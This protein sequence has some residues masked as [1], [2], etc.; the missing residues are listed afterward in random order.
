MIERLK[1]ERLDKIL[2]NSGCGSR[3]DVKK[4]IHSGAVACDGIV[5]KDPDIKFVAET[6]RIDICGS[7]LR[8]SKYVYIMMH[9]PK[10][11]IS[12]SY[13]DRLKTVADLLP[14]RCRSRGLFP[15]GRLDI[16][17]TGLLLLTDDGALAHSL[18]SPKKHIEKEYEAL[19]DKPPGAEAVE[20]FERGVVLNGDLKL[21]PAKLLISSDSNFTATEAAMSATAAPAAISIPTPSTPAASTIMSATAAR[22][23]ITE[24]KFHQIKRMFAVY[25][26]KVLELKRVRMGALE[27]D[28]RLAPG[29]SRELSEHELAAAFEFFE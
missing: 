4:L 6:T 8:Y 21:Q 20:G 25:G 28:P 29:E 16:D 26:I 9:K 19:L 3:S 27:L 17:T 7:P 2:S 12:A 11:V 24:G 5:I 23:V 1:P 13:D 14:E 10:G 15:V 18:L 22:V